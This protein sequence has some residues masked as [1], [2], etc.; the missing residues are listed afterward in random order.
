M[1]NPRLGF[2]SV[3]DFQGNKEKRLRD[4]DVKD[5]K[6]YIAMLALRSIAIPKQNDVFVGMLNG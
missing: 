5:N 1:S 4:G 2:C 6:T 3:E